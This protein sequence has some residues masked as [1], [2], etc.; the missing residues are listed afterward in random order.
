M[1]PIHPL[2]FS[3]P[4]EDFVVQL[5]V[6]IKKRMSIKVT[7]DEQWASEKEMREDLGWSAFLVLQTFKFHYIKKNL[8]FC[9]LC[10]KRFNWRNLHFLRA[11]GSNCW[12]QKR[13]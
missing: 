9:V 10:S 1:H 7:V 5:E 12:G 11:R 13:L 6:T 4:Q 2:Y 8:M 3:F